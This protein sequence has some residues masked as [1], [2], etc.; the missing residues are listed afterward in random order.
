MDMNDKDWDELILKALKTDQQ[1]P[2]GLSRRLEEQ[3][4]RW[5]AADE[6]LKRKRFSPTRQWIGIAATALLL[7]GLS[8]LYLMQTP[9][10]PDTYSNPKEAAAA[11]EKALLLL[12]QNLNKGFEQVEKANLEMEKAQVI[13]NKTIKND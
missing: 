8:G 10:I 4:D 9:T 3:I 11:T 2:D 5:A 12:S 7:L 1:L 6:Q 13:L